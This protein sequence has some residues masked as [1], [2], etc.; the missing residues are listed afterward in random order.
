MVGDERAVP[1][2]L[3]L[4]AAVALGD[5]DAFAA[6][7]D[8]HVDVVFGVVG[9]FMRE[10]AAAEEVVQEAFLALW[11]RADQYDARSGT[12]LGWLLGIARHRSIDR[13]RAAARRP[14]TVS[15]WGVAPA[16]GGDPVEWTPSEAAVAHGGAGAADPE[17]VAEQRWAS[18][19]VRTA[20]SAIPDSERRIVEL[21]Y[22]DGLSQREIAERLGL[23][24]GTVKSRTRRALAVLRGVLDNVPDLRSFHAPVATLE[25]EEGS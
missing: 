8:R 14:R 23:P 16:D 20:L 19:V 13:L 21:A 17:T 11:Q 4:V 5:Q 3:Q 1:S 10:R 15:E 12:V 6:L 25:L 7:Y 24:L 22:D 9:R 18:A 2:D